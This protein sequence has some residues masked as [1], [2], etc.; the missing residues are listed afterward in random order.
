MGHANRVDKMELYWGMIIFGVC[1]MALSLCSPWIKVLT[2]YLEDLG[3]RGD[4]EPCKNKS[5]D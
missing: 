4:K 2:K 1:V 5:T 3:R